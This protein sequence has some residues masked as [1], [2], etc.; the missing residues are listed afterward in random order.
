M[1]AVFP[2]LDAPQDVVVG[3]GY[4]KGQN[5]METLLVELCTVLGYCLNPAAHARLLQMPADDVDRF[6]RAV[7]EA[8]GLEEPYDKEEWRNVSTLVASH[9]ARM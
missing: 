8:E 9:F 7:F 6:T 2:T 4:R 3:A 5:P 1:D